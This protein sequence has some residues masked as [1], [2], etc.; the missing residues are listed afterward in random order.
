M[1]HSESYGGVWV[2]G[3]GVCLQKFTLGGGIGVECGVGNYLFLGEKFRVGMSYEK[4][5]RVGCPV[6]VL[7]WAGCG[8]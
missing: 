8:L 4:V 2:D 6:G 1:S 7:P 3:G 5:Q